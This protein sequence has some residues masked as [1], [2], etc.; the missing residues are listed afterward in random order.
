MFH[1]VAVVTVTE[2][3]SAVKLNHLFRECFISEPGVVSVTFD[4]SWSNDFAT[5]QVVS[6]MP[7]SAVQCEIFIE[8]IVADENAV[9]YFCYSNGGMV[10]WR[11][12][13]FSS[14][15]TSTSLAFFHLSLG[16][17][18]E[19]LFR[20]LTDYFEETFYLEHH[21]SA[22]DIGITIAYESESAI[23]FKFFEEVGKIA[24]SFESEV[25]IQLSA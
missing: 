19:K 15:P 24:K 21:M 10:D 14:N 25:L 12:P 11:N 2:S 3:S 7:I 9:G 22:R 8:G 20:Q 23:A 13:T 4:R 17:D 6:S 16:S 5:F 1:F 18:H